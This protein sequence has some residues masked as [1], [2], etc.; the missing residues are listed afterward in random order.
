M[1]PSAIPPSTKTPAAARNLEY[2]KT[3]SRRSTG[4][5]AKRMSCMADWVNRCGRALAV[6][7]ASVRDGVEHCHELLEE[8]SDGAIMN[9]VG[10]IV[11][12]R[13]IAVDDGQQRAAAFGDH[14]K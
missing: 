3:R 6:N 2:R 7:T 9:E 8:L 5:S 1:A 11:E 14:G 13:R 4:A 12:R 10:K